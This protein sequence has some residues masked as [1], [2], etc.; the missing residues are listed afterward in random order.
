MSNER[1][2]ITSITLNISYPNNETKS[3]TIDPI[4][5]NIEGIAWSKQ[6]R[7]MVLKIDNSPYVDDGVE[8]DA[9]NWMERPTLVVFMP[10]DA[11]DKKSHDTKLLLNDGRT[12]RCILRACGPEPEPK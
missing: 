1:G 10:S 6:L 5:E 2:M 11:G 3:I 4:V 8:W 12:H 9:D 7:D